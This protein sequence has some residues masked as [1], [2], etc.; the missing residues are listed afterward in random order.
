MLDE[1]FAA[2]P[3]SMTDQQL[4]RGLGAEQA[5]RMR[6][7]RSREV[8]DTGSESGFRSTASTTTSWSKQ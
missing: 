2:Q 8:L 3:P 7:Q 5:P 1:F 4:N 6:P